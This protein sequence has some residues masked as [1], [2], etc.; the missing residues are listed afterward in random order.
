MRLGQGDVIVL[1][2]V[3]VADER[4]QPARKETDKQHQH[5]QEF[6]YGRTPWPLIL[7]G[8]KCVNKCRPVDGGC[9]HLQ[10]SCM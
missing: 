4:V 3:P 10:F 2:E 8:T 5:A 1:L 6:M 7:E 9:K